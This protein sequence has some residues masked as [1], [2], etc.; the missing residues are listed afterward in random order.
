[1]K[2]WFL[3]AGAIVA[4]VIATS[5][6]PRTQQFTQPLYSLVV[7]TGYGIA[8]YLLSITV[9]SVPLGVTYAVW[10]GTGIVLVTAFSW[11]AYGQKLS[12]PVML[13]MGLILAGSV[14]V[15]LF[16]AHSA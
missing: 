4:E 15:N 2:A 10:S 1:M 6:M 9:K 12:L 7:L 13:G 14:I 16:S 5:L 3:L 8:F 11:F